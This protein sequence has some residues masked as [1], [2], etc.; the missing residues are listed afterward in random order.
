VLHT[1]GVDEFDVEAA[2]FEDL[3][4]GDPVDAGGLHGDGGHAAGGEPVGQ[5]VEVGGEGFELSDVLALGIGAGWDR[6]E[7]R[8]GADVDAGGM[9]EDLREAR[10]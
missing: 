1:P 2:F 6:D 3:E 4:E 7:V 8:V 10:G 5:G 9:G